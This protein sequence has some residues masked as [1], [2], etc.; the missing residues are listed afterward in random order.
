MTNPGD[1]HGSITEPPPPKPH[2][3]VVLPKPHPS[4]ILRASEGVDDTIGR[5]GIRVWL[6]NTDTKPLIR[7][8]LTLSSFGAYNST[9]NTFDTPDFKVRPLL[10]AEKIQPQM[11]SSAEWLITTG[12]KD[13]TSLFVPSSNGLG[14]ISWQK[15]GIWRAELDVGHHEITYKD[16]V[17]VRWEPGNPPH[18]MT[19]RKEWLS[20]RW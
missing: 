1:E 20:R 4:L 16:Y 12:G 3:P 11:A 6:E 2:L 17:Y 5:H 14:H 10:L 7:C 9:H 13:N 15:A 8:S 18:R 19:P